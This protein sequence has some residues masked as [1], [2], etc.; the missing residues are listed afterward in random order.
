VQQILDAIENA[1]LKERVTVI[2][3]SDHGFKSVKHVIRLD[4]VLKQSRASF[5]PEGGT[6]MVYFS[7][8]G[9]RSR[10]RHGQAV[11]VL[12]KVEGVERVVEPGDYAALGLPT[13]D[14]NAQSPDLLLVAKDGYAFSNGNTAGQHGY[15]STDPD[16][17]A[18]FI[19]SG[20]GIRAGARADRIRNV[21]VA[22]TIAALLGIELKGVDGRALSEFLAPK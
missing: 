21:D 18:I 9:D 19:A 12:K 8:A 16:M 15:L 1:G 11:A 7:K 10:T 4:K 22:P 2:V 6:A 17:D 3:V 5:V 14:E 13:P 20:R